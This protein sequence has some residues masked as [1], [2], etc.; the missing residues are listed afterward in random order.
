MW[1]GTS[2]YATKRP[3]GLAAAFGR[4]VG[5]FFLGGSDAA[6]GA[7][8]KKLVSG[9]GRAELVEGHAELFGHRELEH[10]V[11]VFFEGGLKGFWC[12]SLPCRRSG[13]PASEFAGLCP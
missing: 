11:G 9:H 4:L 7:P 8:G 3:P 12:R 13:W 2:V 6:V 1:T 10:P 5:C